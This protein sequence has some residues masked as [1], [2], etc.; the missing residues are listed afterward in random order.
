MCREL[1][2]RAGEE[3]LSRGERELAI[4]SFRD[5]E[6][7]HWT[8]ATPTRLQMNKLLLVARSSLQHLHG[9][10]VSA[11]PAPLSAWKVPT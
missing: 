2:E 3:L 7:S 8:K 5:L 10:V 1:A 9:L 6:S 11:L 4:L